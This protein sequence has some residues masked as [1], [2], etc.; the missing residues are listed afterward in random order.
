MFKKD[1]SLSSSK[2]FKE[3]SMSCARIRSSSRAVEYKERI[4]Q[5]I[6]HHGQEERERLSEPLSVLLL[7][8]A[9]TDS[10]H[11]YTH[12]KKIGTQFLMILCD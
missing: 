3:L 5:R 8:T 1:I 4:M 7:C 6:H 11:K 2:R 12:E 10:T 9:A